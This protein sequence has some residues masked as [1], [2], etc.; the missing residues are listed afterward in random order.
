M[1]YNNL[2]WCRE[3]LEMTQK[4]LSYVFGVSGSTI[5]GWENSH[6]CI[7]LNKM[8]RF[9]NLYKYSLDFITGLSREN[10][11]NEIQKLDKSKIGF[12]LKKIRTKLNLTQKKIA[13]E[14]GISQTAYSNYETG[15]NLIKTLTLYTICLKHNLSM[16][17]LINCEY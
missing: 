3:E 10:N 15:Q 1:I 7:P 2:K 16:D 5:A 11:Y 14:C 4:K 13:K 8:I 6:D 12:Q 17:K 9:S